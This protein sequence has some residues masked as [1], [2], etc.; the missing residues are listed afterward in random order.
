MRW[1][2]VRGSTMQQ[3]R[4]NQRLDCCTSSLFFIDPTESL[5]HQLI[6]LI[7]PTGSIRA[8]PRASEEVVVHCELRIAPQPSQ[9]DN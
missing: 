8:N 2:S 6:A 9:G 4:V 7:L 3:G 1:R 5:R